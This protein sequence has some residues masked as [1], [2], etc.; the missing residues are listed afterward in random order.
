M[1]LAF[2]AETLVSGHPLLLDR[3]VFQQSFLFDDFARAKRRLRLAQILV[4]FVARLA[5][6]DIG[7]LTGAID[8]VVGVPFEGFLFHEQGLVRLFPLDPQALI[9][10][11]ALWIQTFVPMS[12]AWMLPLRI[13]G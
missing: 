2:E 3:R 8:D 1:L 4:G 13:S 9:R 7:G 5:Q 6:H 11:G 12:H 10:F